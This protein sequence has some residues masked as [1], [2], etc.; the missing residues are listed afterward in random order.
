MKTFETSK[1]QRWRLKH[2]IAVATGPTA[3]QSVNLHQITFFAKKLS[4]KDLVKIITFKSYC[5]TFFDECIFYELERTSATMMPF[6]KLCRSYL[7]LLSGVLFNFVISWLFIVAL[8]TWCSLKIPAHS[9]CQPS[10]F[11]KNMMRTKSSARFIE[12]LENLKVYCF[13][14]ETNSLDSVNVN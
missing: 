1:H 4:I 9:E 2:K 7:M 10:I 5:F 11:I 8:A 6:Y 14:L 12:Y 3:D 13:S